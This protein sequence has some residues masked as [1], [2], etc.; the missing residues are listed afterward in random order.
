MPQSVVVG[1]ERSGDSI[2]L[3][4]N[5]VIISMG[6]E[7]FNPP[8]VSYREH[9]DNVFV[10]GDAINP[11]SITNANRDGFEKAYVL[12]LIVVNRRDEDVLVQSWRWASLIVG[13]HSF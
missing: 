9:F 10:I 4:A 6:T 12:E 13:C 1:D 7:F 8:D 3:A 2:E 5:Y 11:G